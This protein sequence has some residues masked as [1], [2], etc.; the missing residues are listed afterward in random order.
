[1]AKTQSSKVAKFFKLSIAALVIIG[2]SVAATLFYYLPQTGLG[3]ANAQENTIASGKPAVVAAPLYFPLE[4]F[5]VTLR[6]ER[7]SRIL[8]VAITLRVGDDFTR[9][10]LHE[11]TPE[12]RDRIL[13]KLSEQDPDVIQTPEGRAALVETLTRTISAPYSPQPHGPSISSVLFTAFVVQ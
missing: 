8:Y 13:Q 1:M 11:Y 5:T 9:K 7:S 2:A 6:G 3:Q 12:V 4:P 10:I